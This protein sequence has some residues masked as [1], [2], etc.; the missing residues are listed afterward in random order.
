MSDQEGVLLEMEEISPPKEINTQDNRKYFKILRKVMS[1]C[2]P[3]N[4]DFNK[5][6]FLKQ[7]YGVLKSVQVLDVADKEY[8]RNLESASGKKQFIEEVRLGLLNKFYEI[9]EQCE[10]DKSDLLFFAAASCQEKKLIEIISTSSGEILN[11]PRYCDSVLV[12]T[13]KYGNASGE[14][15]FDCIGRLIDAEVDINKPDFNGKI[16]LHRAIFMWKASKEAKLRSKLETLIKKFMQKGVCWNFLDEQTKTVIEEISKENYPKLETAQDENLNKSNTVNQLF[17][18]IGGEKIR[19]FLQFKNIRENVGCDNG[20]FTLL[21]F[22]CKKSGKM[23]PVV[24]FLL[25]NGADPNQTTKLYHQHPLEIAAQHRHKQIFMEI[26]K[27]KKLVI[28]EE[29]FNQFVRWGS[30]ALI[31]KYFEM[32]LESDKLDSYFN[33]GSGNTPLHYAA[34]FNCR[35]SIHKILNRPENLLLAR[36]ETGQSVLDIVSDKALEAH[37]D[38]CLVLE[39]RTD[40]ALENCKMRF[41]FKSL[42]STQNN[43]SNE[44]G[45]LLN[46]SENKNLERLVTHPLINIF[47]E[48]KWFKVELYYWVILVLQFY[49]FLNLSAYFYLLTDSMNNLCFCVFFLTLN[50]VL[51]L[52]FIIISL[53]KTRRLNCHYILELILISTLVVGIFLHILRI[54]AFAEMSILLLLTA[55]YHP[56]IAKWTVILKQSFKILAIQLAFFSLVIAALVMS[57]NLLAKDKKYN[58]FESIS[59]LLFETQT[60]GESGYDGNFYFHVVLGC[61]F[62]VFTIFIVMV[63][64]NFWITVAINTANTVENN[65][66]IN[67]FKNVIT[68]INYIETDF[69]CNFMRIFLP[70]PYIFTNNNKKYEIDFYMNKK[71]QFGNDKT[72]PGRLTEDCIIKIKAFWSKS[73]RHFK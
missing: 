62:F 50:T 60:T 4:I 6:E 61:I 19:E 70:S 67:A 12:F 57:F 17:Y 23:Y 39:R 73:K 8:I 37:F 68:F 52:I 2:R 40:F 5:I 15:F 18:W 53:I 22:A 41:C 38:D 54:F 30:K 34:Y 42:I 49:L 20:E 66:E 1:A 69:Y 24:K 28:T 13:L 36:N 27:N 43:R 14:K 32:L 25:K 72:L 29:I 26:L 44:V 65:A 21:Q 64:V 56:K 33:G 3:N 11:Q 58:C 48:L 46:I 7:K 63:M 59:K 45:V 31:F 35:K 10:S 16:A 47:L 71:N 9:C 55:G 51:K